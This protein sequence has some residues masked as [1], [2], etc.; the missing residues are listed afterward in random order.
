[1]EEMIVELRKENKKL[2]EENEELDILKEKN[3]ELALRVE[4]RVYGRRVSPLWFKLKS[5][6]QTRKSMFLVKIK[7]N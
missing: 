6:T 7:T 2:K 1:M 3:E 4:H 5:G